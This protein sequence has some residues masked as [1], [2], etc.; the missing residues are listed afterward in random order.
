MKEENYEDYAAFLARHAHQRFLRGKMRAFGCTGRCGFWYAPLIYEM[1]AK[2]EVAH[3][4]SLAFEEWYN[5]DAF[6]ETAGNMLPEIKNFFTEE[7][8]SVCMKKWYGLQLNCIF[9]SLFTV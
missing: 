6:G 7:F 5:S 4:E 1:A 9:V 3:A 8:W 2:I